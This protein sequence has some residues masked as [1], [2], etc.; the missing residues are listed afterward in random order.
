MRAAVLFAAVAIALAI[1]SP[2]RAY[3]QACSPYYG[4]F[5]HTGGGSYYCY[6]GYGTGT[7]P[8]P[9]ADPVP[10]VS[11]ELYSLPPGQSMS[12]NVQVIDAGSAQPLRRVGLDL[13]TAA[14]V[15][16]GGHEHND[17]THPS[18]T[19]SATTCDTGYD[20]NQCNVT[21]TATYVSQEEGAFAT[22]VGFGSSWNGTSYM[23]QYTDL[24]PIPSNSNLYSFTGATS[25]HPKNH[26]ATQTTINGITATLRAWYQSYGN[27]PL[28]GLNDAGLIYGGWFDLGPSYGGQWWLCPHQYHGRGTAVDVNGVPASSQ[29]TFVQFCKNN[30]AMTGYAEGSNVHCEWQDSIARFTE[31]SFCPTAAPGAPPPY[32][33]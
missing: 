30:G 2:G 29:S 9:D 21:L 1:G 6:Y 11:P 17:L 26:Y 14:V 23:V 4:Y 15:L 10:V 19:L 32:G 18:S 7:S 5:E 24:Y 31:S 33:Y 27:S 22:L 3:S 16:T 8:P 12:V 28:L 13:T 25:A 20:G